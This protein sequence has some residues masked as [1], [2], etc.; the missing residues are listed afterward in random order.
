MPSSV[1]DSAIFSD[2]FGTAAMRQVFSDENLVAQYLAV[3]AALAR[4]QGRLGVIPEEAS[5]EIGARCRVETIDFAEL[6]RAT[7]LVGYPILPLVQ[8]IVTTRAEARRGG[9][10][11]VSTCQTRWVPDQ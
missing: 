1:L 9:R 7:E 3:E 10:E 6:R 5:R 2:L 4:V 8:Q 11:G